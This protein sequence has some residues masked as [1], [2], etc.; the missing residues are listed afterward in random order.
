MRMR[1]IASVELTVL[2]RC[3]MEIGFYYKN[4]VKNDWKGY[5]LPGGHVE[6]SESFVAAVKREMREETGLEIAAPYL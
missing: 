4:R 5:T 6:A 1:R 2:C 3:V